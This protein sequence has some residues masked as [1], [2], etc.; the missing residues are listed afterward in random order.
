MANNMQL[1]QPVFVVG[2]DEFLPNLN[3]CFRPVLLE[4][5]LLKYFA[6]RSKCSVQEP[7][8]CESITRCSVISVN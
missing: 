4:K 2:S 5:Y 7:S 1:S 6:S 3:I 8:D